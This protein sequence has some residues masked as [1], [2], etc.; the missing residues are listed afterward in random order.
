M[1]TAAPPVS[2]RKRYVD[3]W[4]GEHRALAADLYD[5]LGDWRAVTSWMTYV[6]PS[7]TA[8]DLLVSARLWIES[9]RQI[10][11]I[12]VK[13]AAISI[14]GAQAVTWT[15]AGYTAQQAGFMREIVSLSSPHLTDE[16]VGD[17]V[18]FWR[19]SGLPAWWVCLSIAAGE[20]QLEAERR[21]RLSTDDPSQVGLLTLMSA[22]RGVDMR[23]MTINRRVFRASLARPAV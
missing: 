3:R 7:W 16:Q 1:T 18:M 2:L 23:A 9:V 8:G 19:V 5:V 17:E 10:K 14:S 4:P 13:R 20:N 11:D 21:L 6:P 15:D 22:L 12:G